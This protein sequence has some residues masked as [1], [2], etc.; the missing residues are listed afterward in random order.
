MKLEY[1]PEIDGLRAF[2]VLAVI[3][4]HAE[5]SLFDL[6]PFAGGYI[7]VDVF[8]VISGYLITAIILQGLR[9]GNFS[10]R[11]FY[12]RRAR[13]ILP[14]L[15]TVLLA[16]IPFTWMYLLPKAMKEYAASALSSLTFVSNFWFWKEDSYWAE[17]SELKP[18]LHTW[19]LSVEVQY[20]ILF[21]VFVLLLYRL[22]PRSLLTVF[23][24]LGALSLWVADR[25]TPD[26]PEFTFY[27]LPA[28]GWELVAGAVLA[29]LELDHNRP[30]LPLLA[31]VAPGLGLGMIAFSVMCF[32]EGTPHP[33]L[34]TIL[35]VTGT[36]LIIWFAGNSGW[37]TRILQNKLIVGLGLLSYS[38]Y[39]WHVPVFAFFKMAGIPPHEKLNWF[40]VTF[41]LSIAGY[42]LI[43]QPFRRKTGFSTKTL[44]VFVLTAALGVA[45]FSAVAL[46]TGGRLGR[47]EDWQLR[48]LGED[49]S[50][51]KPFTQYVISRY[52]SQASGKGFSKDDRN[53]LLLIGDSYS[54]DFYNILAEAGYLDQ[55]D[56]IA[57]YLPTQCVNS[58]SS[59]KE[60]RDARIARKDKSLCTIYDRVGDPNLNRKISQADGVIV[61]SAWDAFTGRHARALR[62]ELFSLGANNVLIVGR[63]NFPA[64]STREIIDLN[65]EAIIELREEIDLDFY[66]VN[67]HMKQDMP[68]GFL[69]LHRLV[70][71]PTAACPVATPEGFLISYDGGHLTQEGARF[72]SGKLDRDAAFR[73]FW[74]TLTH[75]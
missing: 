30:G 3:C 53:K 1:R 43:E 33:S 68:E 27:L 67:Q 63:K 50:Q 40:S 32:D 2:A 66:R 71:G 5:F 14:V 57:S 70:C 24:I 55:V 48:F 12:A 18:F 17:P 62:D 39:L 60:Q 69:D 19:S 73:H 9:D 31:K 38:L 11:D 6:N 8:F 54:Q 21:P 29:K 45:S 23:L 61:I 64:L 26:A 47:F 15:L 51:K 41:A 75:G 34:T 28:R 7:G 42:F 22:A 10:F 35:P 58:P 20:Y 56:T 59:V 44:I 25:F 4:Y 36:L 72:I 65:R 16:S 46:A 74:E 13:R 52:D 37:T 49:D